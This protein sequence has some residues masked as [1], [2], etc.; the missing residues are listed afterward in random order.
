[1]YLSRL[2]MVVK[3]FLHS[4][5]PAQSSSDYIYV[6]QRVVTHS[7]ADPW[8]ANGAV[9]HCECVTWAYNGG[10]EAEPLKLKAL[11]PFSYKRKAKSWEFKWQLTH[12]VVR[13]LL[14]AALTSPYFW[15]MWGHPAHLCLDPSVYTIHTHSWFLFN[16]P[17]I[18]S[19]N[20][21]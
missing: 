15:S 6:S 4:A 11:C 13:K 17:H 2:Q 21:G 18:S 10:L 8:F 1:M 20:P 19:V 7:V 5:S 3:I 12:C 14:L 9:D 16:E